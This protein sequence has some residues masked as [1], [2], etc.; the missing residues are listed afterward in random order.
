MRFKLSVHVF[1]SEKCAT[2]QI[3]SIL[4]NGVPL[5]SSVS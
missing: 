2:R 3:S 5:S 4:G 1:E